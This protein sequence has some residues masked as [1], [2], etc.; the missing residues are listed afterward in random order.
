MKMSFIQ[1]I[2]EPKDLLL[3]LIREGNRIIHEEERIEL[4][5]HFFN[6][7]VTAH[8]LRDWCVKFQNMTKPQSISSHSAWD[9]KRYLIIAKDVA[10]SVKHFGIDR[11]DPSI[12]G[13]SENSTEFVA[14]TLGENI[15]AKMEKAQT[16]EEY[17]KSVSEARPSYLIKFKDEP[18][19]NLTDY[20]SNTIDYWVDYFDQNG[21]PRDKPYDSKFIFWHR[22]FWNE[23]I[24]FGKL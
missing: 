11:Y 15:V 8:S 5:D 4:T 21:I 13:T 1:G 23:L 17:R 19:F 24:I 16:S 22:K 2:N 10:N 9:R 20:V 14:F 3:K 18:D 12:V 7:S 6:F